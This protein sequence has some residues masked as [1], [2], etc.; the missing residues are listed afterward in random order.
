MARVDQGIELDSRGQ[1]HRIGLSGFVALSKDDKAL[2]VVR[3]NDIDEAA[4]LERFANALLATFQWTESHDFA[5]AISVDTLECYLS[6]ILA[7]SPFP[8][9]PPPPSGRWVPGGTRPFSKF[10]NIE[11]RPFAKSSTPLSR[12]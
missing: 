10:G 4:R 1:K 11:F 6:E 2:A 12:P 7:G 8:V 9:G 5:N 3:V